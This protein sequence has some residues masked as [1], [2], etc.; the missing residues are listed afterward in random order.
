MSNPTG[1]ENTSSEAE[2]K[3]KSGVP[4]IG[5]PRKNLD[6]PSAADPQGEG[7]SAG[8]ALTQTSD[9]S[10]PSAPPLDPPSAPAPPPPPPPAPPEAAEAPAAPGAPGTSELP[11][12]PAGFGV[13]PPPEPPVTGGDTGGHAGGQSQHQG[14]YE[15]ATSHQVGPSGHIPNQG[16]PRQGNELSGFMSGLLDL[17]FTNFV[18]PARIKFVYI[19]GVTYLAVSNLFK[20][21]SGVSS[22]L[23]R[24]DLEA[25]GGIV[26]TLRSLLEA[27]VRFVVGVVFLR[28]ILELALAIFRTEENTRQTEN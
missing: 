14:S 10:P 20:F 4:Y 12:P 2:G 26:L 6:K 16:Q 23:R 9:L 18:T 13:A 5:G 1:P 3:A 27:P 24:I 15:Q 19:A 8:S 7:L 11:A 17:G 22:G 21:I 25:S 28:L